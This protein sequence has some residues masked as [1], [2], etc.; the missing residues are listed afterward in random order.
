M[1][2]ATIWP[3]GS[4]PAGPAPALTVSG[5]PVVA[6]PTTCPHCGSAVPGLLAGCDR[7]DC[8]RRELDDDARHIRATDI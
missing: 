5:G 7:S 6:H 1:T 8:L 2:V 4:T 3:A